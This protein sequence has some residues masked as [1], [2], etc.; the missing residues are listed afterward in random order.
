MSQGIYFP[1]SQP[2]YEVWER[3]DPDRCDL[4]YHHWHEMGLVSVSVLQWG[5]KTSDSCFYPN[6]EKKSFLKTYRDE[7]CFLCQGGSGRGHLQAGGHLQSQLHGLS[8]QDQRGAGCSSSGGDGA[9]GKIC[10][11]TWIPRN[12][13][14][15]SGTASSTSS[16]ANCFSTDGRTIVQI[17]LATWLFVRFLALR[18]EFV[19]MTDICTCLLIS[20][21]H[22]LQTFDLYTALNSP[23]E[24]LTR[25][26]FIQ[27]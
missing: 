5:L 13:W 10:S 3:S 23:A 21:N 8:G 18:F 15:L 22:E 6:Y 27:A 16:S 24:Q 9:P 17:C 7:R 20:L 11:F 14:H 12:I 25:S 1:V 4:G 19:Q 26:L 2:R